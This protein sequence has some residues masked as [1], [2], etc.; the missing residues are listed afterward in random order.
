[1]DDF[2]VDR[3]EI[4]G[5]L[6][7]L[8]FG[9][10]GR[11]HQIWGPDPADRDHGEEFP[12][13][14]NPMALG[15]EFTED[16]FPGAILI[17]ARTRPD[18]PWILSRN[19]DAEVLDEN[20]DPTQVAFEYEFSLLPEI[21][22]TGRYYEMSGPIPHIVW[23]VR[24]EN[25]G[26]VS[27]EIGELAF[28]FA[29]NNNYDGFPATPYGRDL[30]F[31]NRLVLHKSI[32]GAGSF[33]HAQRLCARPPGLLIVPGD[34]TSWEFFASV[35]ASIR[36]PEAW[37]GIPIVYVHSKATIEREGWAGWF[38][39]NSSLVMEPGDVRNYRTLFV[40]TEAADAEGAMATLSALNHPTVGLFPGAVAPIEVG[41]TAQ[42]AG[43]TPTQVLSDREAELE[44]ESEEGRGSCN[45]TAAQPGPLRFSFE[46]TQGRQTHANLLFTEP[47]EDLIKKRARW[48][49]SN[50]VVHEGPLEGGIVMSDLEGSQLLAEP[51]EFV[52]PFALESSLG[53]ALFLAGKNRIYPDATELA[54]LNQYV[55]GFIPRCIQNP[56]TG[57][58][59]F[60]FEPEN[61]RSINTGWPR[62][63]TLLCELQ[64]VMAELFKH[65]EAR[66][67]TYRRAADNTATA[68]NR[69]A[70]PNI[71]REG[72]VLFQDAT[73]DRIEAANSRRSLPPRNRTAGHA[74]PLE[75]WGCE[76]YANFR[77][78]EEPRATR[79]DL[80][81]THRSLS[82]HWWWYGADQRLLPDPRLR[83][84]AMLDRGELCLGPTTPYN[85]I[86]GLQQLEHD[87]IGLNG[88]QLRM[89]FGGLL[90]VWALVREDGAAT[91]GF[92]PDPASE[93]FG[94]C[95][96]SGDVGIGLYAY[97]LRAT[98]YVVPA[99]EF[100]FGCFYEVEG[101]WATVIP[102]D[103]VGRRI[104]VGSYALKVEA[105][106][107]RIRKLR[108]R[109]DR[110][111]IIVDVENP[112]DSARTLVLT[113]QGL[114]SEATLESENGRLTQD[115]SAGGVRLE[116]PCEANNRVVASLKGI[117]AP[118]KE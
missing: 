114:W 79:V 31:N 77:N 91:A 66:A 117:N 94:I 9:S 13:V 89:A 63:Y 105:E 12:F 82:P 72:S 52:T 109:I 27:L 22:A 107:G 71:E 92:C 85:A 61:P 93:G 16:Y 5:A 6:L 112:A 78:T 90:G 21:G 32:A 34:E 8:E 41:I 97:L 24:I 96:V 15:E 47:I 113:V 42:L 118:S 48:I 60:S 95:G 81:Y 59:G 49:V 2:S 50:Q 86:L 51:E 101:P 28:P 75:V 4:N 67:K 44:A 74:G 106:V 14:M 19:M 108:F 116:L 30:L 98:S 64:T 100:A 11:V 69:I 53:D 17:G 7:S 68:F 70:L 35:P 18:D 62:V 20:E 45:I 54:A 102:W 99:A 76:G 104:V 40:P 58:V 1:M 46:D 115:P 43:A 111:E 84:R 110:S 80:A 56:S 29:L 38:N 25:R 23:D 55:D 103:G 10:G 83:N 36:G 3:P 87:A 39:G 26:R 65:D 73:L 57:A 88:G 33:I 37:A